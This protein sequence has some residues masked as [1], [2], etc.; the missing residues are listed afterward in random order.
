LADAR[1]ARHTR[2]AV[3]GIAISMIPG[4]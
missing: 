1:I 3:S 4:G 2:S